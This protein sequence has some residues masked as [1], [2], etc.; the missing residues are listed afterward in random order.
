MIYDQKRYSALKQ[1]YYFNKELTVLYYANFE[2]AILYNISKNLMIMMESNI[3][4]ESEYRFMLNSNFE[5]IAN[6]KNFED[7]YFINQKIFRSYN[8]N[9]LDIIKLK[10]EKIKKIFK[11]EF[12]KIKYQKIGRQVKTQ[13]YIL[14]EFYVPE[15]YGEGIISTNF[16]TIKNKILSKILNRENEEENAEYQCEENSYLIQKKKYS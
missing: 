14:R 2:G 5:L 4:Q 10:E 1:S 7:E 6:T 13:E 8:F 15:K 16:K 3:I 12:E 9:F 11:N